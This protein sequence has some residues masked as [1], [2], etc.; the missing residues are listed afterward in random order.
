MTANKSEPDKKAAGPAGS[1]GSRPHATLDLKATEVTQPAPAPEKP[2]TAEPQAAQKSASGPSAPNPPGPQSGAAKAKPSV[3]PPS[4]WSHHVVTAAFHHVAAVSRGHR[5]ACRYVGFPAC[6]EGPARDRYRP[7]VEQRL[8]ALEAARQRVVTPKST[9][10]SPPQAKINKL[11][12]IGAARHT[13]KIP[14]RSGAT[15]MP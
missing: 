15:S 5:S 6:L 11:E 9:L 12:P 10:A 4:P 14:G 7:A 3:P 1:A 8:S 13:G 2:A